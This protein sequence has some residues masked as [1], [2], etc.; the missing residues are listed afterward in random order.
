MIE[1]RACFISQ[2]LFDSIAGC[3]L[4]F[5]FGRHDFSSNGHVLITVLGL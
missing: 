5:H 4:T 1:E 3:R 2:K